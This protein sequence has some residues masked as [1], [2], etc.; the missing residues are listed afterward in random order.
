MWLLVIGKNNNHSQILN[1]C[2]K[3]PILSYIPINLFHY[4][5][6]NNFVFEFEFKCFSSVFPKDKIA[7][8]VQCSRQTSNFKITIRRSY[9]LSYAAT[10][11]KKNLLETS[12]IIFGIDKTR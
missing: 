6:K 5:N 4:S 11:G 7:H 2:L 10:N 3:K 12:K 1:T 9:R 8:N